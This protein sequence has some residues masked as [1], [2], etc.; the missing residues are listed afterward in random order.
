MKMDCLTVGEPLIAFDSGAEPLDEVSVVRKY[1]VGAESNVAIGLARLGRSVGYVGRVGRDSP[2]REIVR[3]LRGE[4]VDVSRLAVVESGPTAVLLKEQR[5]GVTQVTY[6]RAGSA[7]STLGVADLPA[8]FTGIRRLHVTGITLVLSPTARRAVLEAMRRARA[9]GCRVSL[10]ANFRRR[11]APAPLLIET[12]EEAAA[13]ADDVIL[14]LGEAALCAG[15]D[16]D[17]EEYA[18]SVPAATVVLKGAAG[19]A[20]AFADGDRIESAPQSVAVVDA[21]GSGD[22]FAVGYLHALLDG[23]PLADALDLGGRVS[24]RVIGRHGDYQGLP[25]AEDLDLAPTPAVV[26]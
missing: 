16:A 9:D 18:R 15:E 2:G 19:G 14:G 20:V 11:L 21:V 6:H 12:F 22:G 7:G 13:L 10:D 24:A 17:P 5:L 23:R 3:T 26:R 4:G 8:R 25:Y 1:A